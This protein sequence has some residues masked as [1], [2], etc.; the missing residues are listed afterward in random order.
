[1]TSHVTMDNPGVDRPYTYNTSILSKKKI[2]DLPED[3]TNVPT[4]SLV[5]ENPIPT[6][7][8][9]KFHLKTG[10]S[11]KHQLNW[12]SHIE[13]LF[14]K[15]NIDFKKDNIS[16]SAYFASLQQGVPRP[17][18]IVGLFPLF[19]DSAHSVSTVK[20][21]MD[22]LQKATSYLNPE[23]SS[24]V[25]SVDQPLYAIAKK[26]QWEFPNIYGEKKFVIMMG[27]LHIKMAFLGVL[28]QWMEGSGWSRIM[29]ESSVSSEG[30]VL[31]LEKGSNT[32]RGQWAHQVILAALH[33][34]RNRTYSI[35]V[36]ESANPTSFAEWEKSMCTHQP[37]F[38]YWNKVMQL[39]VIF[40]TFLHCQRQ[41]DFEMYIDTLSKIVSWMFHFNHFHYARW[42]SVHLHDL[43]NLERLSPYT[44]SE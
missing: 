12:L 28:G 40:M 21:G 7:N 2:D 34:L 5:H 17:A 10:I 35:Y 37:Q 16:W 38:S 14:K 20:H 11:D 31:G 29:K 8:L 30:R 44:Y 42:M 9:E 26:L 41:A 13:T 39:E 3:Y 32:S 15:D 27:G 43:Q 33:I 19:R 18:A 24:V 22:L 25:L 6:G 23:Q 4:V 36:Q 1:M